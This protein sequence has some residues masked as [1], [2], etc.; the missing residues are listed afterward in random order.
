MGVQPTPL[1]PP[2]PEALKQ[3]LHEL[4]SDRIEMLYLAGRIEGSKESSG[5]CGQT[6]AGAAG[7]R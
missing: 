6:V 1:A 4:E 2:L 3:E 5:T 7:N